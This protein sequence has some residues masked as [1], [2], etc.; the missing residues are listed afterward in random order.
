MARTFQLYL[1]SKKVEQL[2]EEIKTAMTRMTEGY[3]NNEILNTETNSQLSVITNHHLH[4][5]HTAA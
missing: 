1:I 3:V 2:H 5:K 4:V